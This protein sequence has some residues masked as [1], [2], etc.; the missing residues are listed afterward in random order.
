MAAPI[1]SRLTYPVFVL[2]MGLLLSLPL[3]AKESPQKGYESNPIIATVDSEPLRISDIEDKQINDLRKQLFEIL[4]IQL[5]KSAVEK[6]AKKHKEYGKIPKFDANESEI[7]NLYEVNGLS[8]KGS[9]EQFYPMLKQYLEQKAEMEFIDE[10]YAKAVQAGLIIPYLQA[11]EDFLVKVPVETAFLRGNKKSKIMFLEFSD[12][13]C[14]FCSR[15]QPT[16]SQLLNQYQNRVV[17]GYRHSPL[18]FHREADEAAIAAECARDQGKFVE[19]HTLM[20]EN[21]SSQHNSNLK[22]FAKQVQL[23][24]QAKFEDCLDKEV[25]RPRLQR[26]IEVATLAGIRGTPGFVIGHYNAETGLVSGEI[27]SGAQPQSVFVET[28]EKYLK[29]SN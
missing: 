5:K 21:P 15:V 6:L 18:P 25:Y 28:I 1:L 13:Q 4:D 10:L 3:S 9:Y 24:N 14:P 22:Q 11:P 29:Q 2:L 8:S 23:K 16:I 26:D 27:I 19:Y 7:R 20:F 12:Y 17:F